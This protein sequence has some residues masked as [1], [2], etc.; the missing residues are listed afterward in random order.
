MTQPLNEKISQLIDNEL[1]SAEALQLLKTLRHDNELSEKLRR[2]QLVSEALQHDGY[3]P[4]RRDFADSIHQQIQQEVTYFLPKK[5]AVINWRKA[6]LAIAA[7]VT[8]AVVW[9]SSSQHRQVPDGGVQMAAQPPLSADQ[10]QA[11]FK[12][13]LQAHD[14]SLY[15]N[16]APR[17][18][19]YARVVGYQQE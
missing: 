1:E 14:N 12:D 8:L 15:V 19:P 6:A 17:A 9:F 11:R 3:L 7:S 10:M 18:Q 13:Y 2:Y 5:K 4:L 16:T